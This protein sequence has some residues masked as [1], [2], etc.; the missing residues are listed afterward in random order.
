MWNARWNRSSERQPKLASAEAKTRAG[1]SQAASG[2]S[3]PRQ[4]VTGAASGGRGRQAEVR[5]A[6][7]ESVRWLGFR[8]SDSRDH[9]RYARG[10]L[11]GDLAPGLV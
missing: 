6:G 9:A 8:G 4:S 11:D 7:G 5:Q 3:P 10:R 2:L 1:R